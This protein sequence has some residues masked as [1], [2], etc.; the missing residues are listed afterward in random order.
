MAN[1][2]NNITL[3]YANT[4]YAYWAREKPNCLLLTLTISIQI[5]IVITIYV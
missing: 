4:L 3:Q 1:N 2:I 5:V